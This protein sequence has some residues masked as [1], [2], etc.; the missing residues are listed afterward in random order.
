VAL[1]FN[2][3]K[4]KK[5]PR[6]TRKSAFLMLEHYKCIFFFLGSTV[7]SGQALLIVEAS[8]SHSEA[9]HSIGLF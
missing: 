1:K 5:A 4:K 7:I 6:W 8:R 3:L 2:H 9:P